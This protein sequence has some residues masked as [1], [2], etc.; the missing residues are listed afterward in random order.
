MRLF[1]FLMLTLSVIG[2]NA[3]TVKSIN[4]VGMVHMSQNVALRML[5]IQ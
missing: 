4:Y 1:L 3:M 2:A 5:E